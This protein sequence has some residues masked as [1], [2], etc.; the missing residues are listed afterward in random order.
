MKQLNSQ[1]ALHRII[2]SSLLSL[3]LVTA[4]QAQT[5]PTWLDWN[6][7]APKPAPVQEATV[8]TPL[9]AEVQPQPLGSAD[10]ASNAPSSGQTVI[11]QN[12]LN[13]VSQLQTQVQN[14]RGQVEEQGNQIQR[15]QKSQQSGFS[16]LDDRI[17]KLE[18]PGAAAVNGSSPNTPPD[19]IAATAAPA[20]PVAST[21]P[22]QPAATAQPASS[23][24]DAKQQN[25]YNAAFTQLK[26]GSYDEAI[27]GFQATI[28]A[29]PQGQWTPSALFWQGETYYVQQKRSQADA[30]YQKILSQFPQSDRVPDALLKTGYIAYD[31][32]K[33]AQARSIFQKVIAQFP[34]SQAANLAK[35]RLGRMDT[36]KR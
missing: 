19:Q 34:Q 2:A 32:N 16:S 20:A 15:L 18:Q 17:T 33:N 4:A 3:A 25:L 35:Q 22:P 12:L 21:A 31:E 10:A 8:A 27:K 30:A 24:N 7:T 26:N 14:L 11:I 6:G 13:N 1:L 5:P 9:G 23:A 28:D 36:E 29:D